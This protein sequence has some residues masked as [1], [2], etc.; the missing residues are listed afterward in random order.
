MPC[1][2]NVRHNRNDHI[3]RRIISWDITTP[4]MCL[5]SVTL[6]FDSS[7]GIK[8]NCFNS[9]KEIGTETCENKL[10]KTSKSI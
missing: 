6:K 10:W 8:K 2:P 3:Q 9:F 4:C 5:P 7:S 1:V